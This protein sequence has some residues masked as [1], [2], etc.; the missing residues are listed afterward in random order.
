MTLED[1]EVQLAQERLGRQLERARSAEDRE[2]SKQVR[3]VGENFARVLYGLLRLTRLHALDNQAF[4]QPLAEWI[5]IQARLMELLGTIHLICVE[6]QVYV[7]DVRIRFDMS[8]DHIEALGSDLRRHNVGGISFNEHLDQTQLRFFITAL[9]EKPDK[10]GARFSLQHKLND[11]GLSAIELHGPFRFR[12]KG[13]RT[14]KADRSF[15]DLYQQSANVVSEAYRNLSANRMPNPLPVRRL[16]NELIDNTSKVGA[17]ELAH[18]H[19]EQLPPFARHIMMVTNLSVMIGREAGFPDTTLG[20]LGVAAMFHD[21]GI[22]VKEDGYFVP[23]PRHNTAGLRTLMRQRG[24]HEAKVRRL[25]AVVE[26]HRSYDSPLGAPSLFAR[27]IHIADDYDILTRFRP[28]Q[29]PILAQPDALARMAAQAGSAYDPDLFQVF[30]NKM[31]LFPPGSILRL[32]SGR[33]VVSTSGARSPKSFA[34]PLCRLVREADGSEPP[35]PL[36]VD[37]AKG[38]RVVKVV[39]PGDW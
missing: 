20:D 23:Y 27:I 13:E 14:R 3:E 8:H 30:V 1:Q 15:T 38:D 36:M 37:L 6:D 19:N 21:V 4:A 7:N 11:A 28:G 26:H 24:F 12:L 33:V 5:R 16:V 34:R 25:L 39:K 18:E 10:R 35:E 22:S 32:R 31:G 2:L 17:A 29:G 9:A